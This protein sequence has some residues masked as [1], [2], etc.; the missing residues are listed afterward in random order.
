M[1]FKGRPE[2]AGPMLQLLM[3][4]LSL[5]VLVPVLKNTT[6]AVVV[7]EAAR[8]TFCTMLLDASAMNRRALEVPVAAFEIVSALPPVLRPSIVTLS[9]PFRSTRWPVTVPEIVRAAPPTGLIA[10]DEYEAEPV[11]LAFRTAEAPSVVS[12]QTSIL[13]TPVCVPALIA[14]NAAPRVA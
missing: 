11:P 6:P 5:P 14:V 1:P 9:A 2:P 3:L 13:M 10:M 8:L 4:L 12:A 7:V